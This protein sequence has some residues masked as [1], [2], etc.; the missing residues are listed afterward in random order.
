MFGTVS[1]DVVYLS[2]NG[3]F[4]MPRMNTI[5]KMAVCGLSA[6]IVLNLFCENYITTNYDRMAITKEISHGS[7]LTSEIVDD[8]NNNEG[9]NFFRFETT[10]YE[11][12]MCGYT[13]PFLFPMRATA[14]Y[15]SAIN[16]D[17]PEFYKKC[18]ACPK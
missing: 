6:V 10:Y 2:S 12:R 16:N 9:D 1:L 3:T 18:S 4:E 13:Y 7:M 14:Y 15:D 8:I 17:L 5:N 11:G